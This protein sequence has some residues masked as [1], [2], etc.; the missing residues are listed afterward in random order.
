MLAALVI[1]LLQVAGRVVFGV[2]GHAEVAVN[3]LLA[4]RQM[5]V[6]GLEGGWRGFNPVVRMARLDLPAGHVAEVYV[7]LDLLETLLRSRYVLHRARIGDATLTLE[8]P[9]GEP[10]RLA[11]MPPGETPF[12]PLPLLTESD[13]LEFDGVIALHRPER[14]LSA[15]EVSYA[16]VNGRRHGRHRVWLRNGAE[17]CAEPCELRAD[18]QQRKGLWPFGATGTTV[19]VSATRLSVPP[20]VLGRGA[21]EIEALEL[22]WQDGADASAGNLVLA[23]SGGAQTPAAELLQARIGAVAQGEDGQHWGAVTRFEVEQGDHAWTLPA[24]RFAARAGRIEATLPSVPVPELMQA[25]RALLVDSEVASRWLEALGID[26][27]VTDLRAFFDPSSGRVG[28]RFD[29]ADLAM[30]D[31]RGVPWVRGAAGTLH[32]Y[33]RIGGGRALGELDHVV[34]MQVSARDLAIAFPDQFRG[35]WTVPAAEGRLQAWFRRDR[36]GLRGT[37]MVVRLPE[38]EARG[39]FAVARMGPDEADR[40]LA[41]RMTV[42]RMDVAEARRFIPYK[43][44][45]TLYEWLTTTPMAGVIN[46]G[47]VAYQGQ[48]R[49]APGDP[50]RRLEIVGNVVDGSIRFHPDWPGVE[51][52][53][54][55][56]EVA[57]REVRALATRATSLGAELAGTRLHLTDNGTEAEVTL[58]A[59]LDAGAALDLVRG[60]PLSEPLAFVAPD[61]TA[62]GPLEVTGRLV[63]PLREFA[64]REAAAAG[65]VARAEAPE[66]LVVELDAT[67][68]GVALGMPGFRLALEALRGPVRYEY[69]GRLASAGLA[70]L[71]FEAPVRI[72]ADNAGDLIELRIAGTARA[73]DI[74]RVAGM[75]DP[76]PAAGPASDAVAGIA[77][78]STLFDARLELAAPTRMGSRAGAPAP[79]LTVATTLEG[80]ALELPAGLGKPADAAEPA[81]VEL[82]FGADLR[83]LTFGYRDAVGWLTFADRLEQGA[84]G[85]GVEPPVPA[86]GERQLL[87]AGSVDR[88]VLEELLPAGAAGRDTLALPLPVRLAGFE[89]GE[90]AIGGFDVVNAVIDGDLRSDG[91]DLR[92][93]ADNLNGIARRWIDRDAPEAGSVVPIDLVLDEVRLPA[94]GDTPGAPLPVSVIG[95]VPATDVVIGRLLVGEEDYGRW[96]FELRAESGDLR[97]RG[98]EA[99]LRDVDVAAT[100]DLVWRGATDTTT[101]TGTLRMTNLAEVLPQWGYAANVETESAELTGTF[102]WPGSPIAFGLM[103][104]AGTARARAEN[105]RF[106]D[107]ES[108][109]GATRIFSLLNFTTFAKRISLDFSDVLGRGTSFERLKAGFS[110]DRGRLDLTDELDIEGSGLRLRITGAIDLDQ[111]TLDHEMIVTLPV[112][113][114]LPWYAAYVALANPIAGIGVLV[115]ERV[116]RKPLEQFSSAKY[117]ITGTVENPEVR[118]ISVF[119]TSA[120]ERPVDP[121]LLESDED[122]EAEAPAS[123]TERNENE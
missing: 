89:I 17:D 87:V 90:L 114:G 93:A 110:L 56:V 39:G 8:K 75:A 5:R 118:L 33:T 97:L 70:G 58:A 92:V 14:A 34:Q 18:L 61:W 63:L 74:W 119:D 3:Q 7:E 25:L 78:G 122:Q 73:A 64:R 35:E 66:G 96:R 49:V 51:G 6:T 15:V 47:S 69:P 117:R 120:T 72:T 41:L 62:G 50:G 84:L 9:D 95:Q 108:G 59:A 103:K 76:G 88:V 31:Y 115:G 46:D 12:D 94:P 13:Q 98:L 85:L 28:Y 45:P 37:G 38:S 4:G 60:S 30:D 10:W 109:G 2:L 44:Q 91:F 40:R 52:F 24:L 101:F 80:L 55:P 86:A 16:G 123:E 23:V 82:E 113:R 20:A 26:A 111:R 1:A 112:S 102:S 54:G 81:E 67:L 71:L 121:A 32:G 22:D 42:D 43:L 36:F 11:G 105:G 79:R 19:R 104:L 29:V 77:T 21:V 107:V 100:E 48:F 65:G 99:R 57:G 116:L 106:L 83:R 68:D 27:A 53:A